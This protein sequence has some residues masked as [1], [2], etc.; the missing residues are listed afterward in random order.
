MFTETEHLPKNDSHIWDEKKMY[1][2]HFS[3]NLNLSLNKI[4]SF[5]PKHD[6]QE[7]NDA[8]FYE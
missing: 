8:I 1:F 2:S 6:I 7:E 3:P 5:C 4:I